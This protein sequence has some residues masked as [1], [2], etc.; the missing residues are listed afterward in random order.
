MY[1]ETILK[2]RQK[3]P[4]VHAVDI[5]EELDYSKSSVSRAVGLLRDRGYITVGADGELLFTERGR[6][7]AEEIYDRHRVLTDFLREVGAPERVA[8]ADACRIE[9]VISA[10]TFA[11]IR[12]H[13]GK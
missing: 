6:E 3:K 11:A 8:E 5:V 4:A 9:H 12:K 1:L 7:R 13:M 10:E 2:L